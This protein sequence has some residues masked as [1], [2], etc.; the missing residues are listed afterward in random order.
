MDKKNTKLILVVF[1]LSLFATNVIHSN[2]LNKIPVTYFR[3][4]IGFN[5][6]VTIYMI[7]IKPWKNQKEMQYNQEQY[8][9]CLRM[10][11]SENFCSKFVYRIK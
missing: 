5:A 6:V 8:H 2:S 1:I 9:D 11:S 7:F 3:N 4:F 10:G